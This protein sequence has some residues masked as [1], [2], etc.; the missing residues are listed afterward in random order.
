MARTLMIVEICDPSDLDNRSFKQWLIVQHKRL[1][2]H[3]QKPGAP[4]VRSRFVAVNV[5][6][7]DRLS[8]EQMLDLV[9]TQL[10]PQFL[11]QDME[12]TGPPKLGI[13]SHKE[14]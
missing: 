10:M 2:Q 4:L 6:D 14:D 5:S 1:L 7:T 9:N 13:H 8:D 11:R 3:L 12:Q